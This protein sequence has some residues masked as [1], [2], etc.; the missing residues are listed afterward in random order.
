MLPLMPLRA[1]RLRAALTDR[2]VTVYAAE[3]YVT[4]RLTQ[5][6]AAVESLH[7]PAIRQYWPVVTR[8]LTP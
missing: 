3:L 8:P 2:D 1:R 6:D 5:L 7:F 4:R